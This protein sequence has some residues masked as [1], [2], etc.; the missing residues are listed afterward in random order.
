MVHKRTVRRS[1][2]VSS[3]LRYD[4]NLFYLILFLILWLPV[5]ILLLI[6]NGRIITQRG[7][8]ICQY[9]GSWGW[10]FFWGVLFF[11]IAIL[12]LLIKGTDIIEE[13][14]SDEEET[15]IDRY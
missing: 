8:Y 4:G 1:T 7:G 2:R 3:P 15:L 11:P 12:L 6:K 5:G 13:V 10:L 9:H 14:I